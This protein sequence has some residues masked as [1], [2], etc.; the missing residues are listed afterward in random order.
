[1][2]GVHS[3]SH[4]EFA[5]RFISA[6]LT[7]VCQDGKKWTKRYLIPEV[8]ALAMDI[9]NDPNSTAKVDESLGMYGVFLPNTWHHGAS[10]FREVYPRV[11]S[12]VRNDFKSS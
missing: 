11:D 7:N 12:R 8:Y 3:I 2:T 5:T 1:M 6:T 9:V 10:N 4:A